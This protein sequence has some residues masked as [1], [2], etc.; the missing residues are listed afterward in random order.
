[1]PVIGMLDPASITLI[2]DIQWHLQPIILTMISFDGLKPS[3]TKVSTK[4]TSPCIGKRTN[5]WR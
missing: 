2:V 5:G 1:M 3:V 4:T